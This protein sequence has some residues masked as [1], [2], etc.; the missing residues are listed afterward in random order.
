MRSV[1]YQALY[2][3]RNQAMGSLYQQYA[4]LA[5]NPLQARQYPNQS[6]Q[7]KHHKLYINLKSPLNDG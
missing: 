5:D 1:R 2:T 6:I 7:K 3:A 4:E